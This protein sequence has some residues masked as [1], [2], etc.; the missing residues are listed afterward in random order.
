MYNLRVIDINT[1]TPSLIEELLKLWENSVRETHLFLSDDEIKNIK[2]YVPQ[3]IKNI[4]I[5]I[6]AEN[7]ESDIVGF[8]GIDDTR[9]KMLFIAT[10]MRGK[11]IGKQ[12]LQY[13]IEH[14]AINSLTVNEQNPEA[15]GFYE[16]MG[17]EV[18]QRTDLDEQGNPY[19]L[20]YMKNK[21]N[22][23]SI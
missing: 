1:R 4:P 9:L 22:T 16:H 5:L 17:F 13:G 8:M 21:K 18:Y 12:L 11:G 15:Q 2:Q 7:I 19:P 3:A 10:S 23:I 6:I 20:L 14:Y